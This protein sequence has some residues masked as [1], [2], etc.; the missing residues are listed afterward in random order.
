[1]TNQQATRTADYTNAVKEAD[2]RIRDALNSGATR[3]ELIALSIEDAKTRRAAWE[4]K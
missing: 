4:Q 2:R 3:D 1:M